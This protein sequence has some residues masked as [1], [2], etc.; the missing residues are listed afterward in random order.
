[1]LLK[2]RIYR[3]SEMNILEKFNNNQIQKVQQER[4][5]P[6][7]KA[8]DTIRVKSIVDQESKRVQIF[9]GICIKRRNRSVSSSFCVKKTTPHGSTEKQFALYSPSLLQVELLKEG[10]VRRA[11]LYYLRS[12]VGK[13]AR[14][15]E[16]I[17]HIKKATG[18]QEASAN[19]ADQKNDSK[20]SSGVAS[21]VSKD[22]AAKSATSGK[23]VK[24]ATKK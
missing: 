12:L 16:K 10:V 15:P 22:T 5:I 11:K 1:M 8:G 9:E 21:K 17:R 23:K 4:T 2:L 3:F 18:P 7:F 13:A 19:S 6:H 14:V 20:L 24:A